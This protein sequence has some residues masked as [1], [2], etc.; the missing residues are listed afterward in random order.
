MSKVK[1]TYITERTVEV[2]NTLEIEYKD[3]PTQF[4]EG[5]YSI[6][7]IVKWID[8]N[9]LTEVDRNVDENS[10]DEEAIKV[11]ISYA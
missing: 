7:E 1:I 5:D 2:V 8:D 10:V 11:S 4:E 3:F 6:E 9:Y